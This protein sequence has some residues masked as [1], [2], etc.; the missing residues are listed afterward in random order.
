MDTTNKS[1]P[2]MPGL[3]TEEGQKKAAAALARR[4]TA[5]YNAYMLLKGLIGDGYTITHEDPE[6]L[7]S[8]LEEADE[9]IK[10]RQK[11]NHDFLAAVSG[12]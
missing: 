10:D 3:E 7:E 11:A 2:I 12:R 1:V 6:V 4:G 5:D 8:F 9:I